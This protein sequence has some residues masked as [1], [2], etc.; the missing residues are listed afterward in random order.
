MAVHPILRE[1]Q[2]EQKWRVRIHEYALRL[3]ADPGI[4]DAP[5]VLWEIVKRVLA[6]VRKRRLRD[7]GPF[8][9]QCW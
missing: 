2:L 5:L 1:L 4:L 6:R 7:G 9:S 8:R 3:G